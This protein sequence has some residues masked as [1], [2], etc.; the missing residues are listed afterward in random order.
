MSLNNCAIGNKDFKCRKPTAQKHSTDGIKTA[1]ALNTMPKRQ[2]QPQPV[3]YQT[4]STTFSS[5]TT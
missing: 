1:V 4:T 3:I 5:A 2:S